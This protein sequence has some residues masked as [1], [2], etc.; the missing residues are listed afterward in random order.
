M[1][2]GEGTISRRVGRGEESTKE[3]GGGAEQQDG[4]VFCPYIGT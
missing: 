1:A 4:S 3:V 2:K